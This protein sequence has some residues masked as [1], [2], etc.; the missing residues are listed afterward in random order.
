MFKTTTS[1]SVLEVGRG[2]AALVLLASAMVMV[3]AASCSSS[4]ADVSSEEG[5]G[6]GSASPGPSNG[7]SGD[8]GGDG[9]GSDSGTGTGSGTGN[10]TASDAGTRPKV[11]GASRECYGVADDLGEVFAINRKTGQ[12]TYSCPVPS[13]VAEIDAISSHPISGVYYY[14]SQRSAELG[15]FS[16]DF[17]EFHKLG[18]LSVTNFA[19]LAFH[20]ETAVLY[21]TDQSNKVLYKFEQ[22]GSKGPVPSVTKVATLPASGKAFAIQPKT[23]KGYVSDGSTLY[24]TD[25][26]TGEWSG[27]IPL[28]S[29][30]IEALFFTS[31]G[32][33][34]GVVESNGT[35]PNRFVQINPDTGVVSDI[36]M[37]NPAIYPSTAVTQPPADDVEAMECNV[38]GACG[39]CG[40]GPAANKPNGSTCTAA[41]ECAS[42]QCVNGICEGGGSARAP[43]GAACSSNAG[44]VSDNCV[45]GV[46]TAVLN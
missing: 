7:E 26:S 4:T 42:Q 3:S 43:D 39:D 46:C 15:W 8:G 35:P 33:L 1:Q 11:Y 36:G 19:G 22:D 18:D 30:R 28:S 5:N 41:S 25:L 40:D 20:P 23:N 13:S 6:A 31:D 21:A 2:L 44:C 10:G 34:Y 45:N 24:R 29:D 12:A 37:L 17:C 9:T 38:G 27:A 14:V 32:T 16:P